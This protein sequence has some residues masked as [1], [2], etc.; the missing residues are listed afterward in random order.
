M[1]W[2]FLLLDGTQWLM[3][4]EILALSFAQPL[5]KQG[6]KFPPA[7]RVEEGLGR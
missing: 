2:T 6:H 7:P 3:V 5:P 1:I 4:P